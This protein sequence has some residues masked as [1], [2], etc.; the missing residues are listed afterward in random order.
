[1]QLRHQE[2]WTNTDS[3]PNAQGEAIVQGFYGQY[4]LTVESGTQSVQKLIHL[5]RDHKN[6][7]KVQLP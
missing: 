6:I 2:W 3:R 5:K 4:L 1:M 7:Y